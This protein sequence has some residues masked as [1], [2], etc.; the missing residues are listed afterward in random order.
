MP[1]T[2]SASRL[3]S[4]DADDVLGHE[5]GLKSSPVVSSVWT[6]FVVALPKAELHL[7][8]EGSVT[9]E[10]ALRLAARH[11]VRLPAYRFTGFREFLELYI[12]LSRCLQEAQDVVEVA[13]DL[14]RRLAAQNVRWAEVTFTPLTHVARG[15]RE[16]HLVAGLHEGR[17]RAE[18]EH[19]VCLRWVFD[20]VRSFPDQAEPTV[21]FA[22]AVRARDDEAVIGVG[23]G[24]P[25]GDRYPM[26]T[27]AAAVQRAKALGLRSLPHAGE[28]AGAASIWTAVRE[29][30]ADRIGHGVRCL[31]DPALVD[32]LR[33]HAIPL[34]VCPGSNVALGVVPSLSQHPL[35]RLLDAG[36]AVS[37][38]SDDPPLFG[39]DLVGELTA[40]ADAFGWDAAM[41]RRLA[42]AS[43]AHA[44]AD[45]HR[46][47]G[48]R[49]EVAAAPYL[50]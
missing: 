48:W 4:D 20:V 45:P 39:T 31:E 21:D 29:L 17:L 40:C 15:V 36:L 41:L 33:E 18:A 13:V 42:D 5:K 3:A 1:D 23:V 37:I 26:A 12:A 46:A 49:A 9:P 34:E 44:F 25:E 30:G 38:G 22:L 16:E 50:T 47:A 27:I 11:G 6:E 10:V 35:P 2:P 32:W 43:F 14:A 8:L 7:H 24:G 19:G 28:N